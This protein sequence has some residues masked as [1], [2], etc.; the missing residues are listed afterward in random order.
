[1]V[2]EMSN[3]DKLSVIASHIK[4]IQF[5]KYN[6]ELSLIEEQAVTPQDAEAIAAANA[7]VSKATAQ[8]AALQ[9]EYDALAE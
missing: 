9:A 2:I 1:M 8:I 7:A 6:A 4:N 3:E 5:N